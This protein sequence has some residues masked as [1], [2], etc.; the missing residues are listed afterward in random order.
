MNNH[1]ILLFNNH[2]IDILFSQM[3]QKE[4]PTLL[5]LYCLGITIEIPISI[6][7]QIPYIEALLST[8]EATK[9]QTINISEEVSPKFLHL[10]VDFIRNKQK[11][12]YLKTILKNEFDDEII[13]RQLLYLGLNDLVDKIYD[14]CPKEYMNRLI[15]N[16]VFYT[17][18]SN[19]DH[20]EIHGGIRTK[21]LPNNI[22]TSNLF[23][24][25]R[26]KIEDIDGIKFLSCME[27]RKS[28]ASQDDCKKHHYHTH[29]GMYF[30]KMEDYLC[31]DF[32]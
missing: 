15:I 19:N 4:L 11:I 22:K 5:K 6:A 30:M 17:G 14:Y 7:K 23:R 13:K 3:E 21:K 16:N 20:I 24:R 12:D 9:C 10:I 8:E 26:G 18:N 28:I 29:N 27:D 1:S 25:V 2:F 32:P 31:Y